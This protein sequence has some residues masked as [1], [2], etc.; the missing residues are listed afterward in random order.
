MKIDP[1]RDFHASFELYVYYDYQIMPDMA[2]QNVDLSDR[3]LKTY[4]TYMTNGELQQYVIDNLSYEI[5]RR[6]LSEILSVSVDYTN[7]MITVSAHQ[8]NAEYC[9]E[10]LDLVKTALL[11]K[12]DDVRTMVAEHT[13]T[14][15]NSAAYET[16]NLSLQ[17]T[18][19]ANIQAVTNLDISMQETQKAYLEWQEDKEGAEPTP[20]YTLFEQIKNAIKMC[21]IGGVVGAVLVAVIIA[22][23]ALLSGKLLNPEDVKNRF[24]LRVIGQLPGKRVKKPFAFV[25][26]WFA[27]FGGITATPE[28]FDRLAK[29]VGTSIKSDLSAR[30][31]ASAWKKVA[32]TGTISAEELKNVVSALGMGT[33]Y[34]IIC[35]PDVLTNADSIE[36]ISAA[37]C[38]VLVE[39]QEE[40]TLVDITKELEALK[41][42]NKTVLGAVVINADAVM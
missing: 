8:Q 14:T 21:I 40:S 38:V 17:E 22:F 10:L 33:S 5:E 28:D 35:A 15:T 37:D 1:L 4:A 29:M 25:S 36:K 23:G 20:E 9:Q 18:Q 24:G 16:V 19:K 31:E 26:R 42:W 11:A 27:K 39:K 30:G 12:Y 3:I 7:N 13:L 2:Y 6:Y 34:S 41:A 32:F